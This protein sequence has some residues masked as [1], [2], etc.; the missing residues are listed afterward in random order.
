VNEWTD[1]GGQLVMTAGEDQ[2]ILDTLHLFAGGGRVD[3]RRVL[4][5]R[6]AS[7]YSREGDGQPEAD[8][9]FAKGGAAA[10]FE[11]AYRVGSPVVK[12]LVAGWDRYAVT[13][14]QAAE[15][16]AP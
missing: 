8:V 4:I 15:T 11:A 5:L 6:T 14:P 1:G 9:K 2:A 16:P 3:P 10:A 13:L 7:N 12:A